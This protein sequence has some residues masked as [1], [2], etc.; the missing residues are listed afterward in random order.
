MFNKDPKT[1]GASY[2]N[3]LVF[4]DLDDLRDVYVDKD[5]N[6]LYLLDKAKVY[7]VGL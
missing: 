2:S 3:Q 6:K 4:D 7:E 5:T 1:G